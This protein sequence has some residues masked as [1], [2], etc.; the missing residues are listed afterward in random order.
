[1]NSIAQHAVPK[2]NG[3][4]ELLAAQSSSVSNV[5]VTQ[6]SPVILSISV[7][8]LPAVPPTLSLPLVTGCHKLGEVLWLLGVT[9]TARGRPDALPHS[10]QPL[11]EEWDSRG[12]RT[13]QPHP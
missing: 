11:P 2:G 1:M 8:P 5:V 10:K 12:A 7:S 4:N 6:L 13:Q 3:Q 9:G